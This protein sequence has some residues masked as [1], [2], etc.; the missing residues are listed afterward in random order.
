MTSTAGSAGPTD[1]TTSRP[2][3]GR[4]RPSGE[5]RG[6]VRRFSR[7]ERLVHRSTSWL[8]LTCVISAAFLYVPELGELVGRRVLV[9]T[10]HEWSG[11]L[12]PVPF[13][14]GL[15]SHTLRRDVGRL[16]RFAPYDRDWLRAVRKRWTWQGARPAGK[17]NAGQKIY[18]S[19]IAGATLIMLFTGLLMWFTGLL[20]LISRTS[21]TFIHDWLALAVG[22]VLVGHIGMAV[23]D[24]GARRGMRTGSVERG[25][26]R[27]EHSEWD[28]D[29]EHAEDEAERKRRARG[30][31]RAAPPVRPGD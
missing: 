22:I 18:A 26:A 2:S 19:W 1:G 12:I 15:V 8:M 21:A 4:H 5:R 11:I 23:R 13:L 28:G 29:A 30:T 16:N 6:P 17:F 14:A 10:V 25:W 27:R 9:V 20:P 3:E 7:A 31:G 24:P